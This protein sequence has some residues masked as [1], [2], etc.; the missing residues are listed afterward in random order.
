MY[1]LKEFLFCF[2]GHIFSS[3]DFLA[4]GFNLISWDAYD[5]DDEPHYNNSIS[6]SQHLPCLLPVV[7]HCDNKA[8]T[9]SFEF[10]CNFTS[11]LFVTDLLILNITRSLFLLCLWCECIML[12]YCFISCIISLL[13]WHCWT[14]KV[15]DG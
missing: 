11:K 3:H 1:F 14:S 12:L 9:L 10:H 8:L 5:C 4:S 7:T 13:F 2:Y 15:K 6:N